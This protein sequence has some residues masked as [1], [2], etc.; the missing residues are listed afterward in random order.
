MDRT[1]SNQKIRSTH[2]RI[3]AILRPESVQIDPKN[4]PGKS[5][6]SFNFFLSVLDQ[7]NRIRFSPY[8][9]SRKE[10]LRTKSGLT[11]F[12][13]TCWASSFSSIFSTACRGIIN[14]FSLRAPNQCWIRFW[15]QLGIIFRLKPTL[16]PGR[17]S[18]TAY[19]IFFLI[20]F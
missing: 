19:R 9:V 11:I 12:H 14:K 4:D 1:E 7:Y 20:N 13:K 16:V 10:P 18:T 2:T 15:E 5:W 17:G 6:N 3:C 8:H